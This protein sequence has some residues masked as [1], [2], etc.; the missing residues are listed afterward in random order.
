MV[1]DKARQESLCLVSKP[2]L[3]STGVIDTGS[4]ESLL[5]PHAIATAILTLPLT[6]A[7]LAPA[8]PAQ[9]VFSRPTELADAAAVG[10]M[11]ATDPDLARNPQPL[12]VFGLKS[13]TGSELRRASDGLFYLNALVNGVPVRFL[14]DTGANAVVLTAED[15]Q[16]AGVSAGAARSSELAQ[17]AGG[18]VA[19][20]RIR[21]RSLEA[22]PMRK[23]DVEVAVTSSDLTVSLLG[24]SWLS[25]LG[26][27]TIAGD[28]MVLQ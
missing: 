5:V 28:R 10:P 15:A 8:G 2:P 3:S 23:H 22:G 18:P 26:S 20:S 1:S 7:G 11:A 13:R 27:V 25:Q 16:R 9:D 4:K 17:T 14:V 19:M 6:L 12:V 24:Q 21:L